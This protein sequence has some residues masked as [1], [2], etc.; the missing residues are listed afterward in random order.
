GVEVAERAAEVSHREANARD[1]FLLYGDAQLPV[2][3]PLAPAVNQIG[4]EGLREPVLA[5]VLIVHGATLAIG[6]RITQVALRDVVSSD[7]TIESFGPRPRR[8]ERDA[9]PRLEIGVAVARGQRGQIL[10]EVHLDR[11]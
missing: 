1:Q 10:A 11:R 7:S 9:A 5:K 2:V 6:R 4:V 8:V 3:R